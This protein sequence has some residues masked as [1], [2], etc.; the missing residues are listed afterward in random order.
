MIDLLKI[1]NELRRDTK[2]CV[3]VHDG[4]IMYHATPLDYME[5]KEPYKKTVRK[6]KNHSDEM[7]RRLD[8][9]DAYL[10]SLEKVMDPGYLLEDAHILLLANE[11]A[12]LLFVNDVY[13]YQGTL[14]IEG[15]GYRHKEDVYDTLPI[16]RK[17]H[18]LSLLELVKMSGYAV[19]L[20]DNNSA[21]LDGVA[22]VAKSYKYY[23]DRPLY[24]TENLM[25]EGYIHNGELQWAEI[26]LDHFE[27]TKTDGEKVI[28]IL[29][30][31]KHTIDSVVRGELCR[32]IN[33]RY[34]KFPYPIAVL[35][36]DEFSYLAIM[37][38]WLK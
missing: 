2:R 34:R 16:L 27:E 6:V 15:K 20:Q 38:G 32:G 26:R 4:K 31:I 24:E 35:E 3:F 28:K 5:L 36:D 21:I 22:Y 33:M 7:E 12:R 19:Y 9:F 8:T 10:P 25:C 37:K 17:P 18:A 30:K 23:R 29:S 1:S 14:Y 13:Y 11:I